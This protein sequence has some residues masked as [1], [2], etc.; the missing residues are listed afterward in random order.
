MAAEGIEMS[1]K[2]LTVSGMEAEIMRENQRLRSAL[3]R[4]Q[5]VLLPIDDARH[6]LTVGRAREIALAALNADDG[7]GKI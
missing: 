6:S 2:D 7:G 4:I 3:V 1:L 5:T